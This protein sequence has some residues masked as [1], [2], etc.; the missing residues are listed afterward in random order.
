MI[1]LSDS[2]I[3][4]VWTCEAPWLVSL[5]LDG[6][7]DSNVPQ[8]I[9]TLNCPSDTEKKRFIAA[10]NVSLLCLCLGFLLHKLN[11]GFL[12]LCI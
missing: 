5:Y 7:E 4:Y 12:C 10:I 3:S 8:D 9:A 2:N 1:E 6:C 11:G